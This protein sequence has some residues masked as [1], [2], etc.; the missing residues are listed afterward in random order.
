MNFLFVC[1]GNVSRS[2][3]ADMLFK[4]EIEMHKID[5]IYSSSAGFFASQGA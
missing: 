3:L 4:H 1:T 2:F 5:N